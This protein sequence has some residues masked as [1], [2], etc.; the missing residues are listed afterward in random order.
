MGL[1]RLRNDS[2]KGGL[3]AHQTLDSAIFQQARS[4]SAGSGALWASQRSS[5][6]IESQPDKTVNGP[7]ALDADGPTN[8]SKN[9]DFRLLRHSPPQ[10]G[11]PLTT[12][13][14]ARRQTPAPD[15]RPDGTWATLA[16][17]YSTTL[18]RGTR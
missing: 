12:P 1:S 9:G 2:V 10:C 4:L 14:V 7:E 8:N 17:E 15:A 18:V 11:R 3:G 6:N 13:H 5:W 16:L